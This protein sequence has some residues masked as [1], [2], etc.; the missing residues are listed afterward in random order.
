[1]KSLVKATRRELKMMRLFTKTIGR[2]LG[3]SFASLL[4]FL[5]VVGITG[6][7]SILIIQD[8]MKNVLT[9][10]LGINQHTLNA[11]VDMLEAQHNVDDYLQQY[12]TMGKDKAQTQDVDPA[13]QHLNDLRDEV[14]AL[15]P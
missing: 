2:K 9:L 10:N 4:I 12:A 14:K 1:M 5:L 15:M 13:I 3:L 11:W 7:I 8:N 6:V